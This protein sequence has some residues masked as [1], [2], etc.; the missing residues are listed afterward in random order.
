[1]KLTKWFWI[2]LTIMIFLFILPTILTFNYPAQDAPRRYGFPLVFYK[3][4][5]LINC[6]GGVCPA[7]FEMLNLIIDIAIL[8][9]V[10][11]IVNFAIFYFR[12]KSS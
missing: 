7:S 6:P 10:P 11:F 2:S 9:I 4:G 8:I 12:K 1:M 3:E 5:G